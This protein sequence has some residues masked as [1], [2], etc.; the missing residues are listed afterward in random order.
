MQDF[1]SNKIID[2]IGP[3]SISFTKELNL[4]NYKFE[5]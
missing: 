4:D 5:K 3:I 2:I 1:F